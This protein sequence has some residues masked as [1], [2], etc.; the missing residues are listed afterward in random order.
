MSKVEKPNLPK[1]LLKV[2]MFRKDR[3]TA[4]EL[5]DLEIIGCISLASLVLKYASMESE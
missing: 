4:V 5:I 2:K 3:E 1:T